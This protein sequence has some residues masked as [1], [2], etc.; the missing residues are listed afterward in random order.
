M[1]SFSSAVSSWYISDLCCGSSWRNEDRSFVS[2]T[3][4]S[5]SPASKSE[6]FK[7]SL[8]LFQAGDYDP[9][10]VRD[11][12]NLPKY[13]NCATIFVKLGFLSMLTKIGDMKIYFYIDHLL[14]IMIVNDFI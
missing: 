4:K 14:F 1:T 12:N 7:S 2:K 5:F 8:Q 6:C 9:G 3:G 11:P 10:S 13:Q